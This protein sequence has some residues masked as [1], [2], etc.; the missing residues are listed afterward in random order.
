MT[1]CPRCDGTKFCKEGLTPA[2]SQRLRC[3]HCQKIF[4]ENP[5]K[6]GRK[7]IGDRPLTPYERLKRF[8]DKKNKGEQNG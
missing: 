3:T 8:K 1:R 7:L 6:V 2:G 5:K 4:I